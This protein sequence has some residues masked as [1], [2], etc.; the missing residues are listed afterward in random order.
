[1]VT[2]FM[3]TAFMVTGRPGQSHHAGP[4]GCV[5]NRDATTGLTTTPDGRCP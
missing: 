1:M 5:V 4:I 3:V 2:A